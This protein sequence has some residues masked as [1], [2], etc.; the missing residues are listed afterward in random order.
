MIINENYKVETDSL[1]CTLF[2]RAD[3]KKNWIPVGYYSDPH[4][5]LE[6]L[7]KLEINGTGLPDF[8]T[9]CKKIDKL[10]A[11]IKTIKVLPDAVGCLTDN[12]K[13][14]KRGFHQDTGTTSAP[15]LMSKA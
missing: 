7:V 11:F 8:K 2:F 3:G 4:Y 6:K 13:P 1:N 5:C 9:I 10:T 12:T 14:R 15:A